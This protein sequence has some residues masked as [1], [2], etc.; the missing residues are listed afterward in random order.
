MKIRAPSIFYSVLIFGLMATVVYMAIRILFLFLLGG[1][2]TVEMVSAILL[3]MAE[4]FILLHGIGYIVNIFKSRQKREPLKVKFK[5]EEPKVAILVAARHEPRQILENTFIAIKNLNYRNKDIYFLDDSSEEK[6]IKEAEELCKELGIILFRRTERHGAKAGIINDCLKTL[7]HKYILVFDADQNPLPEFLN[8]VIPILEADDRLAFVQTPQFYSNIEDSRVARGAGFQQAVFY[9]YI[10]EGKGTDDSMFCCG[11]NVVFRA[12]A[13]K[14]VGGLD[15][16]TVTEDF[17]T[18]LKLH[19]A[20]WKSV[21]FE[22][23]Y[24]FGMGPTDLAGYFKQQF[25]WANGTISVLRRVIL[26]FIRKPFS[27]SPYQWWEYFLSSSYYFIGMAYFLLMFGPVLYLLFRVPSFFVK[28]EVYFLSYIPY[29]LLSMGIFYTLL[30]NRNYKLK[31]LLH[32]QLLGV[33]AFPTYIKGSIFALFGIKTIFGVTGKSVGRQ[34]PLI[35]LWPQLVFIL[36]YVIS[37]EWGINRFI[38]EREPAILVNA[39]WASYHLLVLSS[40]FYF[41]QRSAANIACKRLPDNIKFEYRILND[42]ADVASLSLA[43]WKL[44]FKVKLH[45]EVDCG[46]LVTCKLYLKDGDPV[47]FEARVIDCDMRNIRA[48]YWATLGVHTI[49]T[50]Q[51]DKLIVALKRK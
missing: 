27:L 20:G 10:C 3:I 29:I 26:Q 48:G 18:S 23:V 50:S 4:L 49:A 24:A 6:Y 35:Y 32:G 41:N 44:C 28:P 37:I 40:I 11:T 43:T 8:S 16:M 38:H 25:R 47:I 22:H 12:E 33:C 31:D 46:T 19:S 2:T 14:S 5:G 1:Y 39:A 34:V 17:A 15:E 36:L 9:E 7:D 51:K 13:L 42:V 30:G 45:Q 21:Y